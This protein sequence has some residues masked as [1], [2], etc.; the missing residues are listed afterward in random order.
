MRGFRALSGDPQAAYDVVVIGAGIG[1][2]ICA[3]LMARKG[4]RVLLVEQHYMVGGYC[5]TFKRGAFTFDAGT[6]CYPL[7]GN[8]QTITGG[9][10]EQIGCRPRWVKMYPV[11][12]SHFPVG[13]SVS[14]W[15]D[16][17][18]YLDTRQPA[19]PFERQRVTL[20]FSGARE[21]CTHWPRCIMGRFS[22]SRI[23]SPQPAHTYST[24]DS[25]SVSCVASFGQRS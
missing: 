21:S 4:A 5:S 12:H 25:S 1:G 23:G 22:P 19:V 24:V 20:F 6:H 2:L 8:P 11:D 9:L 7:L 17:G 3:G 15:A 16:V 13:S 18:E 14:V 10:I